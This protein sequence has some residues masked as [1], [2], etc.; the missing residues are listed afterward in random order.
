MMY[1]VGRPE[2]LEGKRFF[3]LTGT[4]IL[5]EARAKRPL[6][7]WLPEPFTVATTMEKSFTIVGRLSLFSVAGISSTSVVLMAHSPT[8]GFELCFQ[9]LGAQVGAEL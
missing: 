4:P 7:V 1:H 8:F 9:G 3:V 6:A 2:I 5:K